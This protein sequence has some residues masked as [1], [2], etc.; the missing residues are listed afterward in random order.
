V[1]REKEEIDVQKIVVTQAPKGKLI[2]TSKFSGYDHCM[3]PYVGCQFGCK[4]CYVRFFIKAEQPWG[5]WVKARRHIPDKLEGELQKVG[6]TRLVLGTMCD[7]YQ[8][9]EAI[10]ML[11]RKALKIILKTTPQME[12]V[13]IFT[14]CP[15]VL[16]DIDLIKQLPKGRVHMTVSPFDDK[17]RS[18]IEPFPFTAGTRFDAIKRL[19]AAGIRVHVNV[20]PFI[21]VISE[22]L[23]DEYAEKLADLQVDE[24]FVDPMQAYPATYEAVKKSLEGRPE[25]IK[26]EKI[27]GDKDAYKK[28]KGNFHDKW[29]KAWSKVTHKSPNTMPLS[30][31]HATKSRINMN[32]GEKL[33]WAD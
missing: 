11:T 10:E 14:R 2:S 19:K 22:N 9:Q 28:W 25:W 16:R 7:P 4:Y 1:E 12:K 24:F 6:P 26:I 3:N 21:P 18:K 20:A 33:D 13:G 23:I 27:M 31:D 17:M 15:G 32:T 8:P 29:I 30:C 5:E